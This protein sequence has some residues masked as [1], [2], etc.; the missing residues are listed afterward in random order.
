M[1]SWIKGLP[2]LGILFGDAKCDPS[3]D[4]IVQLFYGQPRVVDA[5][6]SSSLSSLIN[7]I[8]AEVLP[9]GYP[10][11][12]PVSSNSTGSQCPSVQ[13]IIGKQKV[14]FFFHFQESNLLQK[15]PVTSIIRGGPVK[16]LSL[17]DIHMSL[18]YS[19]SE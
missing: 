6:G 5:S 12:D 14:F 2:P 3:Q 13:I 8:L 1:Q 9:S 19:R 10:G 16:V 15:Y 17:N 7:V 11:L 4:F 18:L